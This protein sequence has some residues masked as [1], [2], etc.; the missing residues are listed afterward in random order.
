M[1]LVKHSLIESFFIIFNHCLWNWIVSLHKSFFF[2]VFFGFFGSHLLAVIALF[3]M[4]LS[5]FLCEIASSEPTFI[6]LIGI[7]FGMLGALQALRV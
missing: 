4:T 3:P 2:F 7:C 6:I 1:F 5:Y